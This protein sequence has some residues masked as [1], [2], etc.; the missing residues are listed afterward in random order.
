MTRQQRQ[1]QLPDEWR[2]HQ[3]RQWPCGCV[4]PLRSCRVECDIGRV[5]QREDSEGA[6]AVVVVGD[7]WVVTWPLGRQMEDAAED[8]CEEV[9]VVVAAIVVVTAAAA[10]ADSVPLLNE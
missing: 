8:D 10:A 5:Q 1:Q 7:R 4:R 3:Q 9:D 6:I 2:L